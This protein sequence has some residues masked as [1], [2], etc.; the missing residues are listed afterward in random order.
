VRRPAAGQGTVLDAIAASTRRRLEAARRET[1]PG[2]M[3][4]AALSARTPLDFTRAFSGPPPRVIAEVKLASPSAGPIGAGLD[5]VAL[6]DAY[7]RNGAAAISVVT[8]PE[9]FGGRLEVLEAIRRCVELPILMKDFVVEE[10]QLWQA[11]SNGADAVL[12]IVALL[13]G[14]VLGRMIAAATTL[15]LTPLVEV[16][17]EDEMGAAIR[18]GAKLVG[19]NNRNLRTLEVDLG[20]S[21]RIASRPR[22]GNV[23]LISESGIRSRDEI[24]ELATLGYGGF[25][26]GTHLVRSGNPGA[27][28]GEL[29]RGKAA[30]GAP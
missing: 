5:P 30:G 22:A 9:F 14:P 3:R 13:D 4:E 23:T 24:D 2:A 28:L 6:A 17:D 11:R 25:L 18:A 21:R 29:L 16:H 27:A 12:L 20:V 26:V 19:V 7:S 1:P 15:G 10:Y 8:E